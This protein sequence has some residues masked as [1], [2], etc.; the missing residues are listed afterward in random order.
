[1]TFKNF[2][3]ERATWRKPKE[4]NARLKKC[5]QLANISVEAVILDIGCRDG[6]LKNHLNYPIDY[7]GIDIV[8]KFKGENISIQDITN[9]TDFQDNYFDYVFCIDTLEHLRN[10]FFV[11]KEIHRILKPEGVLLLSVPNPYHFKEILWNVFKIKDKQG[12]IFSWTPQTL[13][14]LGEFCGYKLLDKKG[15]YLIPGISCDN[16]MTRSFIYKFQRMTG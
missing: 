3:Q 8:D 1:M 10:P 16:M 6:L 12:H 9:G 15:T 11:L 5:A 14:K 7:Y 13:E 4:E 2:Y